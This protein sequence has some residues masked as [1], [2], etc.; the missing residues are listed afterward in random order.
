MSVAVCRLNLSIPLSLLSYAPRACYG[1]GG[2]GLDEEA[3]CY[4]AGGGG[5]DEEATDH[6][7][8]QEQ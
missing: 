6:R 8:N 5:L 1:A 3:A 4:G 7:A 2:G